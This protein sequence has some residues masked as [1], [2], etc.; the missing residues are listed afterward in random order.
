MDIVTQGLLGA[1]VAQTGASSD[2]LQKATYI[3]AFSGLLADADTLIRS[4]SDPLLFLEYHRHFTH[5]LVF[6]PVGAL[7]ASGICALVL[8]G[9]MPF[10]RVYLFALL[11]YAFSGVLDAC[12]SYGTHLLWPFVDT[13][14]AWNLIAI[15]DP[16]FSGVLLAGV[17]L[18]YRTMRRR[19][20]FIGLGMCLGYLM[21]G[22]LQKHRAEAVME[23]QAVARSHTI[24]AYQVK[25]TLG[26]LVLWRATYRASGRFYVD[27]IR[28]RFGEA[29]I[30]EGA[31]IDAVVL[32]DAFPG[33]DRTS[34]LYGDLL[35][36]NRFANG[37][38][39]RSPTDSTIIGDVR[40]ALTPRS[41]APLWGIEVDIDKPDEHAAYRTF[42]NVDTASRQRFMAMLRGRDLDA[43]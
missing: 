28:V 43:L 18:A 24:E 9:S 42:R 32:E 5:A 37:F 33:L 21:L 35:R 17:M 26:N 34:T 41:V 13:R 31:A 2:S 4:S 20:V 16:L 6:I 11:G 30:Y 22:G 15:V 38:L 39:A 1:A 8:R 27:A 29:R 12:T 36:F 7:V 23:A 10:R 14:I 3:G 25:P 40:Y 19:W